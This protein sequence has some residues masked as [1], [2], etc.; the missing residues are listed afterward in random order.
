MSNMY[1][2][3]RLLLRFVKY[4]IRDIVAVVIIYCVVDI[5]ISTTQYMCSKLWSKLSNK[6]YYEHFF[7]N[8][9]R[10]YTIKCYYLGN[11]T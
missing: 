9:I 10:Y 1:M 4:N 6:Q 5:S 8:S 11:K 7:V 2:G 3:Y